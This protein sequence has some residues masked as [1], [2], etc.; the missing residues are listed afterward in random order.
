M[1]LHCCCDLVPVV[2]LM[3]QLMV[4]TF[5]Q[6]KISD[7]PTLF[8]EFGATWNKLLITDGLSDVLNVS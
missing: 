6:K 8:L 4:K 5:W 2:L 1:I 3:R 7:L